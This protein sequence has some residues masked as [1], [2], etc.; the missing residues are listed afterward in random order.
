MKGDFMY[1]HDSWNDLILDKVRSVQV[2]VELLRS[3]LR[4]VDPIAACKLYDCSVILFDEIYKPLKD[5][6]ND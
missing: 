2:E 1:K 4:D 5:K 3:Y 6:W